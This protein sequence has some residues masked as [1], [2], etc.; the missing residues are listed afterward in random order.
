M[1][2]KNSDEDGEVPLAYQ[3]SRQAC[4]GRPPEVA[5]IGELRYMKTDI[6]EVLNLAGE[7]Y[8]ATG[9]ARKLEDAQYCNRRAAIPADLP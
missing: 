1:E 2:R 5:R 7:L 6:F 3:F 4:L 9:R 8:V